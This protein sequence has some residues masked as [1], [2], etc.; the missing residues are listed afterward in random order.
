MP[1]LAQVPRRGSLG[2]PGRGT[3]RAHGSWC[4]RLRGID[5]PGV[6]NDESALMHK[7]P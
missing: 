5:T 7:I 1:R 3:G 6:V 2:T 4:G